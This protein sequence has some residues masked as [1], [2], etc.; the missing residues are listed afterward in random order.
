MTK[1]KRNIVMIL[2]LVVCLFFSSAFASA[3]ELTPEKDFSLEL[4]KIQ[5]LSNIMDNSHAKQTD[6]N[7][8]LRGSAPPL[9]DL[10]IYAAISS[11][12]PQYEYFSRN[13]LSSVQ[14]HGGAELYIVTY[15]RGYGKNRFARMN[16]DLLDMHQWLWFDDNGDYVNDGVY[17]WWD[18]SGYPYGTFTYEST[19]S[20]YPYNR[21]SDSIYIN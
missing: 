20:N 8:V 6:N 12:Y 2:S 11:N 9:T 7:A 4:P 15:E 19:S 18:A 16:G 21:M 3:A 14:D 10:F 5:D 13:Q 17:I 1:T